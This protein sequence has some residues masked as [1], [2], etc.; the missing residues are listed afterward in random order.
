MVLGTVLSLAE[1]QGENKLEFDATLPLL[2]E[3]DYSI[4]KKRAKLKPAF[5][6]FWGQ[7]TVSVDDQGNIIEQLDAE[8]EPEN[9]LE[10]LVGQ[11]FIGNIIAGKY[12]VGRY[13]RKFMRNYEVTPVLRVSNVM[14][15]KFWWEQAAKNGNIQA[16]RIMAAYDKQWEDY[17]L[18]KDDAEVM[19]WTGT[20][21]ILEGQREQGMALLEQA[22]AKNYAPAK[23]M[24][25]QFM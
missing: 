25:Q 13:D 10:T 6:D 3:P 5:D 2:V 4:Y 12:Q 16:Q 23:E 8:F 9:K 20:R 15:G 21:L 14:S 7:A 18:G 24:K 19:A 11:R 1:V 22:I 17:L